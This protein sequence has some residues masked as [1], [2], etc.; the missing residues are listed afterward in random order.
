[1]RLR[2]V[3]GSKE[4]LEASAYVIKNPMEYKGRWSELFGNSY[5]LSVE[6]GMGK[7]K[8]IT[9]LAKQHLE[10]NYIGIEKFSSALI[11]GLRKQE[12]LALLNLFFLREDAEN[13]TEFF[14]EGEVEQIYLN[15][16]DP[17]PKERHAKRR[18]TS[19]KYFERYAQVLAPN[20]RLDFK[21]DN[22]S[23]F[24]FSLKEAELAGWDVV[25]YTFDLHHS[26]MAEGNIMTEYE[27]KFSAEGNPI[28][29]MVARQKGN[30]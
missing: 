13:L 1:M 2:N 15:F 28:C 25:N 11:Y 29:K 19:K 12:E 16:S 26:K 5:P 14:A 10:R 3:R 21:T 18:L 8:F 9:S 20:G 24:E 22:R 27:E 4:A 30:T 6:I 23:L 17:W 7:G